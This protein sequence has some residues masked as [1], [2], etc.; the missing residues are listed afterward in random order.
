MYEQSSNFEHQFYWQFAALR[1]NPVETFQCLLENCNF[2]DVAF[3]GFIKKGILLPPLYPM[4]RNKGSSRGAGAP[5]V[6]KMVGTA[7]LTDGVRV[8]A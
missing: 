3:S 8:A 2:L 5:G 1:Q 4:Q 7:L 6:L